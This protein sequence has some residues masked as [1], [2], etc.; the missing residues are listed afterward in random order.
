MLC[1]SEVESTWQYYLYKYIKANMHVF[2]E[3]ENFRCFYR[4]KNIHINT[5]AMLCTINLRKKNI[6]GSELRRYRSCVDILSKRDDITQEL[7]M[8]YYH[9]DTSNSK[10]N[11]ILW[12]L[13]KIN[14]TNLPYWYWIIDGK[15]FYNMENFVNQSKYMKLELFLIVPELATHVKTGPVLTWEFLQAHP[16]LPW[17]Y[18]SIYMCN[19]CVPYAKIIELIETNKLEECARGDL[20]IELI[21]RYTNV[22]WN[23]EN[24]FKNTP[25]EITLQI[26]E[27]LI[28]LYPNDFDF[29]IN[30]DLWHDYIS[31]LPCITAKFVIK[32]KDKFWNPKYLTSL[33]LPISVR[34]NICRREYRELCGGDYL[35]REH[36]TMFDTYDFTNERKTF[37]NTIN[38]LYK[39]IPISLTVN[40]IKSFCMLSQHIN[41]N[42]IDNTVKKI[43]ES[44]ESEESEEAEESEESEESKASESEDCES[45]E[46]ESEDSESE[47][48]ESE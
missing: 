32:H 42:R 1:Q 2:E 18:D 37:N 15:T 8:R 33:K 41:I 14:A 39:Y 12:E 28:L 38:Y 3:E 35:F 20:P 34:Y 23:F 6:Y 24:I 31:K 27:K 21:I 26:L 13:N 19:T 7:V 30:N 25:D 40:S 47:E 10:K 29:Y 48:N 11:Y 16:E 22:I 36:Q 4:N 46:D 44:E 17:N 9:G 5:L 45:E 43:N